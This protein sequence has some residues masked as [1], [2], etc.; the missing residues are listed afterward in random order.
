MSRDTRALAVIRV[1]LT[2]GYNKHHFRSEMHLE[3][4][5]RYEKYE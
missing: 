4:T 2:S 5:R 1:A 3:K